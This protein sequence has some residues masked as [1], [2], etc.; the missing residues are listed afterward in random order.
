[1]GRISLII[2]KDKAFFQKLWLIKI[3]WNDSLPIKDNFEWD[4]FLES[5]KVVN[6]FSIPRCILIKQFIAVEM[7]G[8]SD[9]PEIAY[10]AVSYVRCRNSSGKSMV[11][12]LTSKS[13]VAQLNCVT[14]PHPELCAGVL[15]DKLTKKVTIALKQDIKKINF[16]TDSTILFAWL[17]RESR[18]FK[19]FV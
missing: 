16:W 11:K 5:L 15:L 12:L 13:R 1:M 8:F 10:G 14:I 4:E 19:T 7:L 17:R 3:D 18:N 2:A 6:G 9:A